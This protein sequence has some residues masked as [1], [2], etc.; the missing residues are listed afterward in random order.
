MVSIQKACR[1]RERDRDR[2]TEIQ[3]ETERE[4]ERDR[5]RERKRETSVLGVACLSSK[6]AGGQ[7]AGGFIEGPINTVHK[8]NLINRNTTH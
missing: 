4:T 8:N 6:R 2:E 5:E 3:R 1:E 7:S